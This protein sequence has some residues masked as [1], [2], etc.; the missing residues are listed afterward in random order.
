MA[1][2]KQQ[3]DLVDWG[4]EDWGYTGKKKK[5]RFLPKVARESLTPAQK[6]AGNAKK[7]EAMKAGKKKAAYTE[8]ETKAYL[9]A[10]MKSKGYGKKK[11]K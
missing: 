3:Q 10:R 5:S 7:R 8:A 1:L 11:S 6:A 4:N 2:K 9:K